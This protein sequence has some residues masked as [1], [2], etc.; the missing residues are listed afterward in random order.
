MEAEVAEL[1]AEPQEAPPKRIMRMHA[2]DIEDEKRN[3]KYDYSIA[4]LFKTSE[5]D[6]VDSYVN[7]VLDT[8]TC[9]HST[10][11]ASELLRSS[12]VIFIYEVIIERIVRLYMC[13]LYCYM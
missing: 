4:L 7:S 5:R 8:I 12:Q 2:D 6:V 3:K 10:V 1:L 11:F 9:I 13:V